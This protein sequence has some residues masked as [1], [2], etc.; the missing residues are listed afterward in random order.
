M[1]CKVLIDERPRKTM[2]KGTKRQFTEGIQMARNQCGESSSSLKS[3]AADKGTLFRWPRAPGRQ[4]CHV[5]V[6]REAPS[7]APGL[8][9]SLLVRPSVLLLRSL[10]DEDPGPG[11][12]CTGAVEYSCPAIANRA[13][14]GS[15]C[16]APL[17]FH[18]PFRLPFFDDYFTFSH[19]SNLHHSLPVLL[20]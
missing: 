8:L 11:P 1:L 9:V 14:Q 6:G 16:C 7:P 20:S 19:F 4:Q 2:N 15:T 12:C 17:D 3:N 13:V 18:S 10:T 5:T